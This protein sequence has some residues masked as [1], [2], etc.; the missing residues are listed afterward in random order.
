MI[1]AL[2]VDDE[3]KSCNVLASILK[4]YCKGVEV[5]GYAHSVEEAFAMIHSHKPDLVFLDIQ[6]PTGDGFSLLRLFDKIDFK[7]VFVTAFDEYAIKA[8]KFSALDYLLKPIN[9]D[10]V[11]AAVDKFNQQIRVPDLDNN[12]LQHLVHNLASYQKPSLDVIALPTLEEILFIKVQ[13]IVYLEASSNYTQFHLSN[14]N[15]IVVTYTLKNYEELLSGNHFLRVHNSYIINLY[16][17]KKYI[18]G[19]GGYVVMSDDSRIEISVRKKE[20]F[21]ARISGLK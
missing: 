18:R 6:M 19:K 5:A 21:L 17:V 1:K 8:I 15:K 9:I 14:G 12:L 3:V 7:I 2:V 16:K 4:D 20:E 13:D 11:I 10:D